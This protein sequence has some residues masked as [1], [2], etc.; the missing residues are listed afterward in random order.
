MGTWNYGAG[1]ALAKHYHNEFDRTVARTYEVLYIAEG[2]I[3]AKIYTLNG[4]LAE[5][6]AVARGEILILLESVHE[7]TILQDNIRVLEVK[8]G[9]YFG[10][11]KDRTRV[12]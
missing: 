6:V 12:D 5:T 10:P 3:S 7:Y 9:P 11:D 8:T 4:R 1:K 2:S